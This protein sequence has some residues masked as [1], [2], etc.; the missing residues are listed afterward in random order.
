MTIIS[1]IERI[2]NNI[3]NAYNVC[4]SKGSVI[5][6]EKNSDNL[7]TVINGIPSK[8]LGISLDD[9]FGTIDSNKVLQAPPMENLIVDLTGIKDIGDDALTNRFYYNSLVYKVLAP[10][11]ENVSGNSA[12]QNMCASGGQYIEEVSCPKLSVVSGNYAFRDAFKDC[13]VLNVDFSSL[14]EVSGNYAFSGTFKNNNELYECN[15]FYNI[16]T[17]SGNYAFQNCFKGVNGLWS[18]TE[19]LTINATSIT[20]SDALSYAFDEVEN[21]Y[22]VNFPN[23]TTVTTNAL[24]NAFSGT[25]ISEIHFRADMQSTISALTGYA[26]KFGA[27][28]AIIYFDL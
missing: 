22:I 8:K 10:D 1:E 2:K 27:S 28:D 4:E 12:L 26:E 5:T 7:A 11:L 25:Y 19:E 21:L 9:L 17:I 16:E 3:N 20:G 14:R 15:I 18:D 23:L 6:V 24:R 13:L